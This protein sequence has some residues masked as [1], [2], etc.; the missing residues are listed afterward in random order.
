MFDYDEAYYIDICT[1]ALLLHRKG[2]NQIY[3]LDY[4]G[5]EVDI[6]DETACK[7]IFDIAGE[8]LIG[9]DENEKFYLN[10]ALE[11][12]CN[13]ITSARNVVAVYTN[14]QAASIIYIGEECSV[15]AQPA[16]NR[17]DTLKMFKISSNSI[18]DYIKEQKTEVAPENEETMLFIQSLEFLTIDDD[19]DEMVKSPASAIFVDVF[20]ILQEC[21]IMKC[22]IIHANSSEYLCTWNSDGYSI[23]EY[24]NK[25]FFNSLGRNL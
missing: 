4:F 19:F 16:K 20:N 14:Q 17:K 21:S 15:V 2:L 18:Y 5:G 9:V 6:S 12:L 23:E 22:A 11:E 25:G 1:L 13:I 7:S 8:G 10:D 24:E 3:C